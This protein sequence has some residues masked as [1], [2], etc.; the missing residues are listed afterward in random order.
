MKCHCSC[1]IGEALLRNCQDKALYYAR[2][3]FTNMAF[4]I[5]PTNISSSFWIYSFHLEIILNFK[6]ISQNFE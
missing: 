3:Y 5:I 2:S 1:T 6:R 4:A